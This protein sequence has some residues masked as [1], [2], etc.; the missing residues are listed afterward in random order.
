[1]H[2][3]ESWETMVSEAAYRERVGAE[4]RRIREAQNISGDDVATVLGWSQSKVSRIETA[5]IGLS[6][7]DPAVFCTTTACWRRSGPSC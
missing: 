7:R 3:C 2:G 5:K 1:M 4:L 6:L